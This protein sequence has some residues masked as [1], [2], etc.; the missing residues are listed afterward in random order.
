MPPC[1]FRAHNGQ[2]ICKAARKLGKFNPRQLAAKWLCQYRLRFLVSGYCDAAS[3]PCTEKRRPTCPLAAVDSAWVVWADECANN[4][5]GVCTTVHWQPLPNL[6]HCWLGQRKVAARDTFTCHTFP[7]KN[8]GV[9]CMMRCLHF[10]NPNPSQSY[11]W[12][13]DKQS[14][15]PTCS[16]RGSTRVMLKQQENWKQWQSE[17]SSAKFCQAETTALD[18]IPRISAHHLY[19]SQPAAG[20]AQQCGLPGHGRLFMHIG[21]T[22]LNQRCFHATSMSRGF[23]LGSAVQQEDVSASAPL[24][25]K[26]SRLSRLQSF[27]FLKT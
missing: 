22:F 13:P 11:I 5:N 26:G 20:H 21:H 25:L 8:P 24:Q 4:V 1:F 27:E 23:S 12:T 14:V 9:Q 10:I 3:Q 2:R 19:T 15:T 17:Q 16:G 7:A 6:Q 18:P